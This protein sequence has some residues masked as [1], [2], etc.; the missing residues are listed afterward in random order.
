VPYHVRITR[1]REYTLA[2][3]KDATWIERTIVEPRQRAEPIFVSGRTFTWDEIGEIRIAETDW[4]SAQLV[5]QIHAERRTWDVIALELSDEWYVVEQGRDV[6]EDFITGPPG[7]VTSNNNPAATTFAANR[8]S[9]MVIYGH[10]EEANTALFNWLRAIGLQPK[11][12]GQLVHASG[13]GSPYIGQVLEQAF[14]DA[15]AVVALFT[16][17]EYVLERAASPSDADAWRLQAW[18]NV[19]LEAGMGLSTQPDRTVLV[20]LGRQE[21]PS[22]LS[23][24]HC[25]SLSHTSA[26][27]LRDLALRLRRA[28][29]DTDETGSDWLDP[30]RFPNR[31]SLPRHPVIKGAAE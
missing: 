3:D 17:D 15:Q 20:V 12:W 16:P 24:R 14:Q 27:P 1:G 25:V 9:V 18:P 2:L 13:S 5:P 7:T 10:D 31:D 26:A 23:G 11:E 19:L 28:G 22:D 29:C 30:R 8:K 4:A 21:L 6:T